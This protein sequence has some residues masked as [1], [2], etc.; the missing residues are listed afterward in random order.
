[1]SKWIVRESDGS[2][3]RGQLRARCEEARR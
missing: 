1:M 2:F 3:D